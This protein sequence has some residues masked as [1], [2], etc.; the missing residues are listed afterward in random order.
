MDKKKSIRKIYLVKRKKFFFGINENFFN[1]LKKIIKKRSNKKNLNIAL[2]YPSNFE[3]NVLKIFDIQYFKRFKFLLPIIK[4]N[5]S[6]DFHIWKKNDILCLNKYG[7]LEPIKSPK[8]EP[9][10]IL[11]PLIAFDKNKNRIGYGKG[12]YDKIL[13]KYS[14]LNKRVLSIGVAF[15]F[16]KYNKIPINNK[17]FKLDYIITEKGII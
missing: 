2:Y 6:I 7:I 8:V 10:V 12:Y 14:N 15:S 4:K 11:V 3:V 1:P 16:Q 17:D 9:S 5:D 13:N